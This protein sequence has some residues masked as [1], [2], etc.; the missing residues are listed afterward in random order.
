M[1]FTQLQERVRVELRRRIERGTLSVSL[2]ARQSGVGQ[3]HVS[4]FLNGRRS[5]SLEA[6]DRVLGALRISVG[7]LL[8]A[9]R[10]VLLSEQ[11]T[12]RDAVPLVGHGVAL[13]EPYLRP[14]V[15]VRMVPLP[16]KLLAELRPRCT[17][18]RRQWERFVAIE[19]DVKDVA[20]MEPV[21]KPEAVVVLDR[22]Y[23]SLANYTP[24][25]ANVY[26]VR[27]GAGRLAMRY[28]EFQADRL[29][30]RGY[31]PG[32]A[33]EVIEMEGNETPNDAIAGRV[34]LILQR[35]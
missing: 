23:N 34:A 32:S 6:L 33:V 21:L 28:V 5:L 7:D 26:A 31:Q 24:G 14:S 19:L 20:G 30:L 9:P 8:P 2:L 12:E 22:H 3:S 35:V 11:L 13:H 1:N 16:G 10:G 18:A 15:V 27:N 4:N 29:V 25:E 17:A